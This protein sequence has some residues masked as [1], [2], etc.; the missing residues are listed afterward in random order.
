MKSWSVSKNTVIGWWQTTMTAL[1]HL[2][3]F[4]CNFTCLDAQVVSAG[5]RRWQM[6]HCGH[7][8][9]SPAMPS[10]PDTPLLF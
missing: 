6:P 2:R 7:M 8:V 10:L 9:S 5:C 3:P 1:Y 4:S